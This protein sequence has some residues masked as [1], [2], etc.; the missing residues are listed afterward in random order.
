[1]KSAMKTKTKSKPI[2][3]IMEISDDQQIQTPFR[4]RV[5]FSFDSKEAAI[6]A[7]YFIQQNKADGFVHS[8][9]F[10]TF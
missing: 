10:F 2:L 9:E 5:P 4:E 7:F 3:M 8:T 6:E 1:M